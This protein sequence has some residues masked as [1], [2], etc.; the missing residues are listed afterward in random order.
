MTNFK[1]IVPGRKFTGDF[2]T[3]NS[4][5]ISFSKTSNFI[6]LNFWDC[7]CA[8][9]LKRLCLGKGPGLTTFRRSYRATSTLWPPPPNP[10]HPDPI[11]APFLPEVKAVLTSLGDLGSK[12]GRIQVQIGS[13]RGS[14]CV[15]FAGG[16]HPGWS[17][18]LCRSCKPRLWK[19]WILWGGTLLC[20]TSVFRASLSV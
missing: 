9:Y 5:H 3:N 6:T 7:F 10:T 20:Q 8:I 14:G 4:P 17:G 1:A 2:A 19:P 18:S 16:V 15:G 11:L 13:R 12:L